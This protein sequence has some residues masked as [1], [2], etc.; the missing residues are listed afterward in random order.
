[1]KGSN[2]PTSLS[3]YKNLAE[4]SYKIKEKNQKQCLKN[5]KK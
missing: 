1:M 4:S 2:Q 5:N 3:F